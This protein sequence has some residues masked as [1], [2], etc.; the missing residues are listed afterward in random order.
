MTCDPETAEIRSVIVTQS[1]DMSSMS[2][3]DALVASAVSAVQLWHGPVVASPGQTERQ[4]EVYSLQ[5]RKGG[6]RQTRER[7]VT[8]VIRSI[9]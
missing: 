9:T 1:C 2:Y 6:V 5:W 8:V 3:S 4:R 7:R